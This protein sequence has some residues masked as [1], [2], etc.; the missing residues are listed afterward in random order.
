MSEYTYE[1]ATETL[2]LDQEKKIKIKAL[3]ERMLKIKKA[4]KKCKRFV[5]KCEKKKGVV[6]GGGGEQIQKVK[7]LFLDSQKMAI[8]CQYE[9]KSGNLGPHIKNQMQLLEKMRKYAQRFAEG[10]R[11]IEKYNLNCEDMNFKSTKV[12]SCVLF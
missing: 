8:T 9:L 1:S 3:Q 5:Q 7:E 10:A 11:V 12:K 4:A 2:R 6:G